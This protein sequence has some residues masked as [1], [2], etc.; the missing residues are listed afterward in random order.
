MKSELTCDG[1]TTSLELTQHLIKVTVSDG[2]GA[3]A[4]SSAGIFVQ[5]QND[6]PPT[7][8]AGEDVIVRLPANKVQFSCSDDR[9]FYILLP[10]AF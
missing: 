10:N 8:N 4:A 3:S 9:T 5:E 7:A 6:Y 1:I 2:D